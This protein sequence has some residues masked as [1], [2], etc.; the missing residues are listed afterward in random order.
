MMS[1]GCK[2]MQH[3]CLLAGRINK[4]PEGPLF[5]SLW[6][7]THLA[8]FNYLKSAMIFWKTL[9]SVSRGFSPASTM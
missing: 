8:F 9:L 1:N 7:E 3:L 4:G 2:M 5:I 6:D